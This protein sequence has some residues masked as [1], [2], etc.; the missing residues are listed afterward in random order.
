MY[1]SKSILSILFWPSL[2]AGQ[3]TPCPYLLFTIGDITDA[4][5]RKG[6]VRGEFAVGAV[7]VKTLGI[8]SK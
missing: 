4:A 2:S 7:D 6:L 5:P 8:N 3:P 1:Q